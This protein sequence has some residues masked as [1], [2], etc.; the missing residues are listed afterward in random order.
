MGKILGIGHKVGRLFEL[1]S[2]RIPVKIAAAIVISSIWHAFLGHPL[3]SRLGSL[4][5]SGCLG[6]IK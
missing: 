5:S 1:K 4:I 3:G 6:P 2:L